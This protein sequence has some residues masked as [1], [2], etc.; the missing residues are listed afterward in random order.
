MRAAAIGYS[1]DMM[2]S[3]DRELRAHSRLLEILAR[4][5]SLD[6][7]APLS[8]FHESAVRFLA[9]VQGWDRVILGNAQGQIVNTGVP[10]GVK[11][12]GLVDP[13]GFHRTIAARKT[14]V[15]DLTGPGP[16]APRDPP[17][18]G[19]R[20]PV[21]IHGVDH[22]L[23]ALIRPEV[24]ERVLQEARIKPTWRPFLI[25]GSNRIISAPRAPSSTGREAGVATTAASFM[26]MT[27]S[28][29]PWL[30]R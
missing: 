21:S 27:V 4:S 2:A 24:F 29:L 13:A 19:L 28:S 23:T 12:P 26:P 18:I 22:V 10:S 3:V 9:Q 15:M 20:T 11:L 17:H 1:A 16:L 5:P 8:Q 25:D 30:R 14:I 6:G 7:D